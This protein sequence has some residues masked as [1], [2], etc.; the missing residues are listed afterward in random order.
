[1]S[2]NCSSYKLINL[3]KLSLTLA[4]FHKNELFPGTSSGETSSS[5]EQE[6]YFS[7]L[8]A[9]TPSSNRSYH[10]SYSDSLT[11]LD[12]LMMVG[13]DTLTI[14]ETPDPLR[15]SIFSKGSTANR[16][17]TSGKPKPTCELSP[18]QPPFC[19]VCGLCFIAE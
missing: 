17:S 6:K 1:M 13:T 19:Y 4:L 8:V 14:P 16:G 12:S 3:S 2:V 15:R 5:L 10:S 18:F 11:S 7:A 9:A